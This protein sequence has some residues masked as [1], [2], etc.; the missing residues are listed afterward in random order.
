MDT[1]IFGTTLQDIGISAARPAAATGV[2]DDEG[3]VSA[4]AAARDVDRPGSECGVRTDIPGPAH[5]ASAVRCLWDEALRRARA[6]LV[7]DEDRARDVWRGRYSRQ[8]G[9]VAGHRRS[10]RGEDD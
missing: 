6:A 4:R 1:R 8:P 2:L 9:P 7:R 10:D 5:G 3:G